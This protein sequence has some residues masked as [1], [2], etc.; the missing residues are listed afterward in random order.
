MKKFGIATLAVAVALVAGSALAKDSHWV[1]RSGYAATSAQIA[2]DLKN[3][4]NTTY[5]PT[6][7]Y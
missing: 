2:A 1:S 7:A 4:N 6:N 3:P 5:V